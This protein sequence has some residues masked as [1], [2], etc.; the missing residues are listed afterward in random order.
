[1]TFFIRTTDNEYI[2]SYRFNRYGSRFFFGI[3]DRFCFNFVIAIQL[4]LHNVFCAIYDVH[5]PIGAYRNAEGCRHVGT[6]DFSNDFPFGC[7]LAY[8]PG[9]HV[10]DVHITI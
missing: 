1:M 10:G 4:D 3:D 5:L 9:S 2:A 8:H 7:E 6:R